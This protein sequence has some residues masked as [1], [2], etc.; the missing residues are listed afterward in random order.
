[1]KTFPFLP[2][3]WFY[4]HYPPCRSAGPWQGTP[5]LM[6]QWGVLCSPMKL[7]WARGADWGLALSPSITLP[8]EKRG[9]R[10]YLQFSA[11]QIKLAANLY[12]KRRFAKVGHL[13]Q[14]APLMP[15]CNSGVP[16]CCTS[17]VREEDLPSLIFNLLTSND[18]PKAA[19]L[20]GRWRGERS[21]WM[22]QTPLT[23]DFTEFVWSTTN[24]KD[25]LLKWLNWLNIVQNDS[26][27]NKK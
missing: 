9:R 20:E 4:A 25:L 17:V 6:E 15:L 22:G 24:A 23:D 26:L 16:S 10:H 21:P 7:S 8:Q 5:Y 3:L 13:I 1:M 2:L 14:S 12:W 27:T 11:D 19:G 18:A